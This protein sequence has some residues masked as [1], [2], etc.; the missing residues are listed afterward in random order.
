MMRAPSDELPI[1]FENVSFAVR[2]VRA[3][4]DLEWAIGGTGTTV[5]LGPNGAGKTT[6]LRLAMG[7]I[8]PTSGRVSW[9][10]RENVPPTR[11]AF[12]FQRPAMLRR[13]AAGNIH[14]ALAA[15][16][17]PRAERN[18]RATT[19]LTQVGLEGFGERPARQLSGGEQQRL[20]LARALARDPAVLFL[21]EP[22]ASLDPASTKSIEDII[23]G[24]AARG[25]RVVMSTHDLGQA[26]RLADDIVLMHRGRT[27]ET[28][29]AGTFFDAP[30]TLEARR[31]LN[32]DLLI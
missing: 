26:R 14:Y 23:R 11:R 25:V 9:G 18:T 1:R 22:T 30:S 16:G 17:L 13:S 6:L 21:D 31:F 19:L 10:G 29:K 4:A 8:R 3:I 15:A 32:G 2:D 5:L 28:G 27:A 7:L 24:I 12:L 20:A